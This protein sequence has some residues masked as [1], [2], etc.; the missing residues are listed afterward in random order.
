MSAGSN[1][2]C[3]TAALS[4]LFFFSPP[5]CA[6]VR[7]VPSMFLDGQPIRAEGYT[8]PLFAL[9]LLPTEDARCENIMYW[10]LCQNKMHIEW[11]EGRRV[12]AVT[13][14]VLYSF[15]SLLSSV[16]FFSFLSRGF[17]HVNTQLDSC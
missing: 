15:V 14:C 10:L 13:Q 1:L 6:H 16:Q 17:G 5:E 4:F 3:A 9:L 7:H 12:R 2:C 8:Y 11:K